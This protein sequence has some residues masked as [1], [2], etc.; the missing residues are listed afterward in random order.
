MEIAEFTKATGNFLKAKDV[1]E[2]TKKLFVIT[3]EAYIETSQKFG[4]ERL[5]LPG[6]L[7]AQKKTF[8]CSKTNARFIADTLGVETKDWVGKILLLNV[9]KTKT[10]DGKLV[11]AINIEK[12]VG[13][14]EVGKYYLKL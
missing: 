11:D 5:H 1:I 2:D 14:D 10:S 6:E 12:V 7:S 8:D 3:G 9:Y 13:D 4:V